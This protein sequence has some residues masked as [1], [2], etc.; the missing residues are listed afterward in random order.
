MNGAARRYDLAWLAP[1]W[2]SQL[3]SPLPGPLSGDL[4]AWLDRGLPAVVRRRLPGEVGVPLGVALPPGGVARRAS[5]LV[6]P[7]A[8]A[9][10]APPLSL[11][12]ALPSAPAAWQGPLAALDAAARADGLALA[13]H[14]S[15]AWQRLS[16]ERYLHPASDVDLL[17]RP[18][19]APALD[20]AL[21]LLAARGDGPPRLDGEVLLGEAAVAWRELRSG[22][23][24]VL[25]RQE[26]GVALLPRAALLAR[27]EA[28]GRP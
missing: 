14:G 15:L 28:G 21:A 9:R 22:R 1:G 18:R 19:D 24:H 6:A 7:E 27:L 20:R 3:L 13:V 2:R 5:L 23:S 10:L 16:G 8:V 12:E 26:A 4:A 25:A 11:A 17:L